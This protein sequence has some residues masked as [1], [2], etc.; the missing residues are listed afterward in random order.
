MLRK[1]SNPCADSHWIR[2]RPGGGISRLADNWNSLG[3]GS[4]RCNRSDQKTTG[5]ADR[6][7]QWDCAAFGASHKKRQTTVT[8]LL[9]YSIS[10]I[11]GIAQVPRATTELSSSDSFRLVRWPHR[12]RR[13]ETEFCSAHNHGSDARADRDAG[14]KWVGCARALGSGSSHRGKAR[15]LCRA[16]S[17]KAPPYRVPSPN[18][19]SLLALK[20]S[21]RRGLR[22]NAQDRMLRNARFLSHETATLVS[23]NRSAFIKYW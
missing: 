18:I 23:C 19:G 21:A 8:A 14:A 15:W 22:P 1:A 20:E 17:A 10:P 4:S 11:D 5:R 6:S 3:G 16:D 2:Q 12:Q 7:C 9:G 13:T